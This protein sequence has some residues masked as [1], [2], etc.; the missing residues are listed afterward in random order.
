LEHDYEPLDRVCRAF[1]QQQMRALA[2]RRSSA[3]RQLCDLVPIN[4]LYAVRVRH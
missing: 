4:D 1:V 3:R 2:R